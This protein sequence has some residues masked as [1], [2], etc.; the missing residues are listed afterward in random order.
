[1]N[2]C[3]NECSG[4]KHYLLKRV[5]GQ[6]QKLLEKSQCNKGG[7]VKQNQGLHEQ[8]NNGKSLLMTVISC[9]AYLLSLHGKL[10][11][12]KLAAPPATHEETQDVTMY[13]VPF[14]FCLYSPLFCT[15]YQVKHF[16]YYQ[17]SQK[18]HALTKHR[19]LSDFAKNFQYQALVA[20]ILAAS[21]TLP[22][23]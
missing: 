16:V 13:S 15:S 12:V 1:M 2:S 19:T 3:H 5:L 22:C 9:L 23:I 7:T 21:S 6:K 4:E 14:W 11:F 8:Q 10:A 20:S 17:S 18:K